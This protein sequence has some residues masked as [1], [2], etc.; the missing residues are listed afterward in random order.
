MS[1]IQGNLELVEQPVT[2]GFDA[3]TGPFITRTWKGTEDACNSGLQEITGADHAEVTGDG[4]TY[5][6]T[7]RYA[8]STGDPTDPVD[9]PV[10]EERL[11]SQVITTS[12]YNHP[13]FSD[14]A[15][16]TKND[17]RRYIE[18]QVD[19]PFEITVPAELLLLSLLKIGVTDYLLDQAV[20]VVTDTA[21]ASYPW[22]IGF[23]NLGKI[24]TTPQM[25]SDAGMVSGWKS[26]LP[27]SSGS[28][29]GFLYGWRKGAPEIN[30]V[31]GNRSQLVQEYT[32]GLWDLDIYAAFA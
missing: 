31:G 11:H 27:D 9:V 18:Q 12:I 17:I 4:A 14:V 23:N 30:T 29:D 26:N 28:P 21:S 22:N 13:Q 5:T 1:H 2:R 19:L 25:I 20:V 10:H 3:Q 16:E 32:F 8:S 24:F 7:A 15:V 6:L